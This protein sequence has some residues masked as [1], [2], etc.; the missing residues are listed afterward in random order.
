[1]YARQYGDRK[2][3]FDFSET[4][5]L[6][7]L[8]FVDRETNSVWSQLEGRAIAGP[9]RGFSLKV[10][11]SLQTTW[12][13]WRELHP[14]T[15]VMVITGEE[16]MPYY[17]RRPKARFAPVPVH[18]TAPLGLGLAVGEQAM[19]FPF[20]QL[21]R[22]NPP[23]EFSLGGKL[24]TLHFRKSDMTAWAEDEE[25]NLLPGVLSYQEGWMRFNPDSTLF[26]TRMLPRQETLISP[27]FNSG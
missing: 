26:H 8:L 15:R 25:G 21:K 10:V 24:I 18:D 9:L 17:Y 4:L 23:F 7:N 27:K 20:G 3:T 12:R 5:Y 6:D 13:L 11:P 14:D 2:L 19:F 22:A 1:M 16:G